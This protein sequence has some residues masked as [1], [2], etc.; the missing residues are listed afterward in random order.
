M[1]RAVFKL[2]WDTITAGQ[3]IFA[4]VKN[5]AKTGD[6]YWVFAHITPSFDKDKRIIAYHFNRRVPKRAAIEQIAPLYAT[7]LAA[8]ARHR[9]GKEA[10]A[11]GLDCLTSA[12]KSKGIAYD[13]SVLCSSRR[14]RAPRRRGRRSRRGCGFCVRFPGPFRRRAAAI[15]VLAA[16][17]GVAL[18][19]ARATGDAVAALDT[20]RATCR[21]IAEGISSAHR[22]DRRYPRGRSRPRRGE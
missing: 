7:V 6:Y 17:A 19:R 10:L 1:P 12:L 13:E 2:L 9:N 18:F 11:A 3:E 8:E 4:Y 21:R 16:I 22:R 20:I 15:V 14:F 5:Q